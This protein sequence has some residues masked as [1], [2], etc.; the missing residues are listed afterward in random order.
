MIGVN[1][2]SLAPADAA[3]CL[4]KLGYAGVSAGDH[5]AT[6]DR[7]YVWTMLAAMATA[8]S[9][10]GLISGFANNLF[11]HPSEFAQAALS[12]HTL[13]NGRFEAGLGAGW[14]EAE[15]RAL[16]ATLPSP[17]ER[18][19]RLVEACTIAAALLRGEACDFEGAYYKVS[20]PSTG[21]EGPKL[22]AAVGGLRACRL[23]APLVDRVEV[24]FGRAVA[25]GS[26]DFARWDELT[27]DDL[28]RRIDVVRDASS[29]VAVGVG[30][31][32][33][34]GDGDDVEYFRSLAR[35]GLQRSLLGAPSQVAETLQSL[36]SLGVDR[37]G[38]TPLTSGSAEALAGVLPLGA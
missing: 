7:P 22:V 37:V 33:A 16:G 29:A 8:T 34:A 32:A 2:S 17:R 6:P 20:Y 14:A 28:R 26:L 1:S 25:G 35:G 19:D 11:R 9:R 5:R 12:L 3:R 21:V 4:E 15:L 23:V 27:V 10:V 24:I 36:A 18:V 31:F 38:V 13:S 30:V